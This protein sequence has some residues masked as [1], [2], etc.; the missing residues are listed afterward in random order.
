MA[1]RERFRSEARTR[2]YLVGNPYAL[3]SPRSTEVGTSVP[4]RGRLR[5]R[6]P[7][8]RARPVE[9]GPCTRACRARRARPRSAQ[10]S[11]ARLLRGAVLHRDRRAGQRAR[12]YRQVTHRSRP[13][14]PP[15]AVETRSLVMSADVREL[16]PLYALG[17]LAPD[18][19]SAV[20][21]A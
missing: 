2:S 7:R 16:L 15:R 18:E 19:A 8:R 11:R 4:Q 9:P 20:E 10:G 13:R 6:G 17:I 12:R 21:R 1:Q 3:A 14:S 5:A